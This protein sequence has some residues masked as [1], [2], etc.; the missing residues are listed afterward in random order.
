M[1]DGSRP[2]NDMGLFERYLTLWVVLCIGAGIG[3]GDIGSDF[4]G[5][6]GLL[7]HRIGDGGRRFVDFVNNLGDPA[8]HIH[9][10]G[11]VA[12]H[13]LNAFGNVFG[14]LGALVGKFLDLVGDNRKALAR[15][16]GTCSFYG[17]IQRKKVCL[18]CYLI[19]GPYY[20]RRERWDPGV[21]N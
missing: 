10:F 6:L 14:S 3:L 11:G 8:D 2:E 16:T 15:L 4:I 7:I 5:G 9:C 1:S 21:A 18:K 13:A 20:L 17:R 19:D 12:L